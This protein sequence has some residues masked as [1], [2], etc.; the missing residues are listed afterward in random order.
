MYYKFF[1]L[2]FYL[3]RWVCSFDNWVRPNISLPG[4]FFLLTWHSLISEISG[5][6]LPNGDGYWRTCL[7]RVSWPCLKPQVRPAQKQGL[8]SLH[9]PTSQCTEK[10]IERTMC[11][12]WPQHPPASLKG[13]KIFMFMSNRLTLLMDVCSLLTLWCA[14]HEF[15]VGLVVLWTDMVA[16]PTEVVQAWAALCTCLAVHT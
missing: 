1:Y 12:E 5:H 13:L 16:P 11:L 2:F 4:H 3:I 14:L 10:W 15:V 7:V 8:H 9:S 6:G